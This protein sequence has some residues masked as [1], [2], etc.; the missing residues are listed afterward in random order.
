MHLSDLQGIPDHVMHGRRDMSSESEAEGPAPSENATVRRRVLKRRT[1]V[2][3]SHP[4][5]TFMSHLI[6]QAITLE[7]VQEH[8]TMPLKRAAKNL[9]V[10]TSYLK[11]LCRK[12][13]IRRW[14][15]RQVSLSTRA[16]QFHHNCVPQVKAFGL[17]AR[18]YQEVPRQF[19]DSSPHN[20]NNT[21]MM[22]VQTSSQREPE[23]RGEPDEHWIFP[24]KRLDPKGSGL[25]ALPQCHIDGQCRPD[26]NGTEPANS[27]AWSSWPD[28]RLVPFTWPEFGPEQQTDSG[29]RLPS[30]HS[31][32]IAAAQVNSQVNLG[33]A[34]QRHGDESVPIL[35]PQQVNSPLNLESALHVQGDD[36]VLNFGPQHVEFGEERLLPRLPSFQSVS[37]AA[38]QAAAAKRHSHFAS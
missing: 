1:R 14:P 15:Y 36:S 23:C 4:Q 9:G 3:S 6:L 28:R 12:L 17:S 7:I 21:E 31:I 30:C 24:A 27:N 29:E 35:G 38:A 32:T 5:P 37:M 34:S 16:C 11:D 19:V 13:G 8:F 33:N 20:E 22:M 2:W 26:W 25:D 10:S 18:F